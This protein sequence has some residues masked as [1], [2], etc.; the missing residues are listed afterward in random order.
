MVPWPAAV[1]MLHAVEMALAKLPAEDQQ[2]F[3]QLWSDLAALLNR[4]EESPK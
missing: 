1:A 3:T 4:A 2:A